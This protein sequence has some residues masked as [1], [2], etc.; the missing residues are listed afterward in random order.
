[1][2]VDKF[3]YTVLQGHLVTSDITDPFF[4]FLI[5]QADLAG[6]ERIFYVKDIFTRSDI[7]PTWNRVYIRWCI[8][9]G[10]A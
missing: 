9:L 2:L 8:D 4:Y 5:V 3:C 6:D 10:N 7:H 1:M